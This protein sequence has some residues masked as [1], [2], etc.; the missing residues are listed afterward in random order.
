MV[1]KVPTNQKRPDTPVKKAAKPIV[2]EVVPEVRAPAAVQAPSTST[3][4]SMDSGCVSNLDLDNQ[5]AD[6]ADFENE[7]TYVCT[8]HNLCVFD[9]ACEHIFLSLRFLKS[10]SISL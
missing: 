1:V 3:E 9:L 6:Y 10:L 5:V 4:S 8:C 7:V 2:E